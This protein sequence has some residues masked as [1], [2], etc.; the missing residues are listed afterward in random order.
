M[1][2]FFFPILESVRS[3]LQNVNNATADQR[4]LKKKQSMMLSTLFEGRP[5]TVKIGCLFGESEKNV[6]RIHGTDM[7]SDL[8]KNL[9]TIRHQ[10]WVAHNQKS[11]AHTIS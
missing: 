10:R 2:S 6:R 9:A 1:H 7:Q 3:F 11:L 5:T 4:D 8:G